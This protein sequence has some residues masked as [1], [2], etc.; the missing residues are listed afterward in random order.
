MSDLRYKIILPMKIVGMYER[1]NVAQIRKISEFLEVSNDIYSLIETSSILTLQTNFFHILSEGN[2]MNLNVRGVFQ[3][4]L[5]FQDFKIA[6]RKAIISEQHAMQGVIYSF[7]FD[8]KASIAVS[9]EIETFFTNFDDYYINNISRLIAFAIPVVILS[10]FMV[11]DVSELFSN[12]YNQEIEI[13]KGRGL[14]TRRVTFIYL[15]I[16]LLE[17]VL[18]TIISYGLALLTAIPL[19][20]I[21]GFMKFTNTDTQLVTGNVFAVMG[22]VVAVLFIISIPKVIIIAVRRRRIEKQ[23]NKIVKILKFISWRD[24][25]FLGIGLGLLMYFL[26]MTQD[27][28]QANNIAEFTTYLGYTIVGAIFSLLGGL[29]IAIKSLSLVWKFIG[30]GL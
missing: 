16:R 4:F 13:L 2:L 27:A 9:N 21:N 29:P 26:G 23:P 5:D 3:L 30:F 12:S 17:I 20:K 19:I 8:N 6:E 7:S 15:I 11:F 10:I 25:F 28:H 22:I 14:S 24:M 1:Y 18:A